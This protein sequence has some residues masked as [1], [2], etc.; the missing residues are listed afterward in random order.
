[1]VMKSERTGKNLLKLYEH[2]LVEIPTEE[3][4]LLLKYFTESVDNLPVD[5]ESPLEFCKAFRARKICKEDYQD[6]IVWSILFAGESNEFW[7]ALEEFY[8]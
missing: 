2:H 5:K 8:A 7:N 4:K 6:L 1:M 3:Q